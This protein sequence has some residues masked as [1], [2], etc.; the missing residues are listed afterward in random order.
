MEVLVIFLDACRANHLGCYGYN[1]NTSPNIDSLAE[2]SLKFLNAYSPGPSSPISLPR[3]FSGDPNHPPVGPITPKNFLKPI[4][5]II[6]RRIRR[7]LRKKFISRRINTPIKFRYL[8]ES[9]IEKVFQKEFITCCYSTNV[10]MYFGF[11][12]GFDEF[13]VLSDKNVFF[14]QNFD[15]LI[16]PEILTKLGKEFIERTEKNFFLYIH[17]QQPH[18]PYAAPDSKYKFFMKDLAKIEESFL[19]NEISKEDVLPKII[20]AY[21][22]NIKWVDKSIKGLIDSFLGISKDPLLVLTSDHGE[23]FFEHGKLQH[24]HDHWYQELLHVPLLVY[25]GKKRGT[26]S[27]KY[28]LSKLFLDIGRWLK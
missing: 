2:D 10:Y 15:I 20:E 6:P 26:I 22:K 11:E 21:D 7:F 1:K 24:P 18:A 17:Y 8:R 27:M 25:N 23:E 5:E 28:F 19:L 4:I 13:I 9:L 16:P 12:K 14:T 3:I